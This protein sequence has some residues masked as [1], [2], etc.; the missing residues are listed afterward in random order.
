MKRIILQMVIRSETELLIQQTTALIFAVP[1]PPALSQWP[2]KNEK[3]YIL[4][5]VSISFSGWP[6]KSKRCQFIDSSTLTS[7]KKK[8]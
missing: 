7:V 8:L 4:Y 5:F 6:Q 1:L 2:M 3:N